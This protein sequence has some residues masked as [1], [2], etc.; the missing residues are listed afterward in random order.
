MNRSMRTPLA[1]K[2]LTHDPRR[3]A[4]AVS[5]VTFAVVLMFVERGF[6]EALFDS[7]VEL[8]RQLNADVLMVSRSRYSLA[9]SNRFASVKLDLA[10][11]CDG[12]ESVHPLYLE[13]YL[14]RLRPPH[15]PSRPIRVV[16]FDP[17]QPIFTGKLA[18][19]VAQYRDALL[20]PRVALMDAASKSNTYQV[21]DPTTLSVD[22]PLRV[23]LA[24]RQLQ[25]IGHF[26]LGTDF[27]NDGTLLM[28]Q[29]N[30]AQY[31]PHRE[32]PRGALSGVDLGLIVCRDDVDPRSIERAVQQAVGGGVLVLTRDAF[33]RREIT[34]WN[35]NTPIG[36]IFFVGV[37]MG[38]IVG[39]LICYQVL[40]NDINDHMAEFAT[41]MAM[42]YGRL[43][44]VRLVVRESVYLSL[45]G[46]IPGILISV[47]LFQVISLWTGLTMRL[48]P[49]DAGI[50]LVFTVVMCVISGLLAVRKLLA[51][52]PASLF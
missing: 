27:A 51:A 28:S 17:R 25:L 32:Y 38:F 2:N 40:F 16:G 23:E 35:E 21:A 50:I 30:F 14:G 6:R 31:F 8:V 18:A 42:G 29:D 48:R 19:R 36:L 41:L 33:V 13:S 24:H 44:F 37:V 45:F 4:I 43:Y 9:S 1:W 12:V 15:R 7:T 3:L 5:G 52:D 34:V 10:R 46:F 11:G 26:R 49:Q 47:G 22:H 20:A 39:V